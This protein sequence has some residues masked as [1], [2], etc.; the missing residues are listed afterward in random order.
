MEKCHYHSFVWRHKKQLSTAQDTKSQLRGWKSFCLCVPPPSMRQLLSY[1]S[2][3]R[4][5]VV[6]YVAQKLQLNPSEIEN[7]TDH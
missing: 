1:M 7:V 4:Q 6:L 2:Y 3:M 5:S